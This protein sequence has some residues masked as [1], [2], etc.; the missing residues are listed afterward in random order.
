MN[1]QFKTATIEDAQV[2]AILVNSAYRPTGDIKGWTHESEL[3]SG[4]RTNVEQV[5]SLFRDNSYV[6]VAVENGNIVACVHI[7]IHGTC[8]HIGMLAT[9]P[10]I[11]G[12]GYGKEMLSYAEYFASKNFSVTKY[13]MKVLL[14]RSE[15]IAFY[16]R[17]GYILIEVTSDYPISSGVGSPKVDGL[18]IGVLEKIALI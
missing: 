5:S 15:L 17:R 8:A 6:L 18:K 11:Q 13:V 4:E 12:L 9:S 14:A 3:I 10:K 1:L 7:E 16:L 2:I